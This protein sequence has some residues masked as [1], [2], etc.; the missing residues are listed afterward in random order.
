[1]TNCINVT[2]YMTIWTYFTKYTRY[3]D[4]I[5]QAA[6]CVFS[7]YYGDD[8][9]VHEISTYYRGW[10]MYMRY[11]Q[12]QN[13]ECLVSRSIVLIQVFTIRVGLCT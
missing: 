2:V 11:T 13:E 4:A 9:L 5:V 1:M 12:G 3:I 6:K 10:F 8:C 7:Y